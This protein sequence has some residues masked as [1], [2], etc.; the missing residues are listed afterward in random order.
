MKKMTKKEAMYNTLIC[1][2]IL[3]YHK[4]K[5]GSVSLDTMKTLYTSHNIFTIRYLEGKYRSEF[6]KHHVVAAIRTLIGE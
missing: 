1:D 2:M 6:T 5:E 4:Y 3:I